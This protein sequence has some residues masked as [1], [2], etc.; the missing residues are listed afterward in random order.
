M[1]D[2]N[3]LTWVDGDTVNVIKLRASPLGG[4]VKP[5]VSAFDTHG[6]AVTTQ[7]V[8]AA[9]L[10]NYHAVLKYV[11]NDTELLG[12]HGVPDELGPLGESLNEI[13]LFNLRGL[14]GV[15]V[16]PEYPGDQYM[17]IQRVG[18]AL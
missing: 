5:I 2:S 7:L 10:P 14:T 11:H 18:D 16:T 3:A 4:L 1:W 9:G 8:A 12:V 17:F 15:G 6:D 13:W